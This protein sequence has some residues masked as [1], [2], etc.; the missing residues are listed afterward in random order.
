MSQQGIHN[1]QADK[2]RVW[3]E[4]GPPKLFAELGVPGAFLFLAMGGLLVATAFQVVRYTRRDET[5]Y[6]TA[7]IFSMLAANATSAIVSAQVFGDPL[8]V[9]LLAFMTGLLF[10]GAREWAPPAGR[11]E[12]GGQQNLDTRARSTA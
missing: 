7:G 5:F 4:S 3:Q 11:T 2:P 8:I 9:L 10:S 12:N 6:F 1:I